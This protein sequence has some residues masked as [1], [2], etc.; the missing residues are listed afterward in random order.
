[1]SRART[2]G[3]RIRPP[4]V[5]GEGRAVSATTE[6]AARGV[7]AKAGGRVAAVHSHVHVH[8]LVRARDVRKDLSSVDT[9]DGAVLGGEPVHDVWM[10]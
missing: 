8:V 4:V 7:S 5:P 3:A 6:T 2:A 9:D 10:V 1:M